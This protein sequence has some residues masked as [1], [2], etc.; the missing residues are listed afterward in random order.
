M[1]ARL[2]RPSS[3]LRAEAYD[4]ALGV[5]SGVV[6]AAQGGSATTVFV[7]KGEFDASV[8]KPR[9]DN[10]GEEGR[11]RAGPVGGE[12]CGE[13]VGGEVVGCDAVGGAAV[14]GEAVGGEAVG[15][16]ADGGDVVGE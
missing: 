15:G 2:G 9:A 11:C 16:A 3:L 10:E 5:G 6:V 7:S 14:G 4:D 8:G 12:G 1:G 13:A